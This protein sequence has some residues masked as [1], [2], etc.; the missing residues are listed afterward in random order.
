MKPF[1]FLSATLVLVLLALATPAPALARVKVEVAKHKR[2]PWSPGLL[3]VH[4]PTGD[5]NNYYI[6][7]KN[8]S[9]H[10]HA[11]QVN[12]TELTRNA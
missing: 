6:R 7:I 11:K 2:G 10:A 12:L 9:H 3:N 1:R 5:S 8:T 4:I